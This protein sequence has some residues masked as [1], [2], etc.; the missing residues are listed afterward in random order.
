[1]PVASFM[2]DDFRLMIDRAVTPANVDATPSSRSF[3]AAP[4]FRESDEGV[5]STFKTGGNQ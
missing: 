1:M 5:A 2:I 3:R 4:I